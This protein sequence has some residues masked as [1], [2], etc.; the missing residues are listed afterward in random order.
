MVP[1]VELVPPAEPQP[2]TPKLQQQTVA[3]NPHAARMFPIMYVPPTAGHSSYHNGTIHSMLCLIDG[4]ASD[5]VPRSLVGFS[6]CF[7][8]R[9]AQPRLPDRLAD[10][11]RPR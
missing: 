7:A 6:R 9:R 2:A 4:Q 11:P 3:L 1:V 10:Q 5:P 8:P